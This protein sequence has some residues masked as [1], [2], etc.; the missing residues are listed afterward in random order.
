MAALASTLH[1]G[2]A[3]NHTNRH[4]TG[5]DALTVATGTMTTGGRKPVRVRSVDLRIGRPHS[6][7]Y[8]VFRRGRSLC[9]TAVANAT[10]NIYR[11]KNGNGYSE[12]V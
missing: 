2:I 6:A 9:G 4:L 5:V 8:K 12:V 10:F 7:W 11:F 1:Y 3:A